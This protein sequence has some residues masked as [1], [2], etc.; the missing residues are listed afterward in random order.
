MANIVIVSSHCYLLCE[1]INHISIDVCGEDDLFER[2]DRPIEF[3]KNAN[4]SSRRKNSKKPKRLSKKEKE[5]KELEERTYYQITVNFVAVNRNVQGRMGNEDQ[6]T[7]QVIVHGRD[8]AMKLYKDMVDQIRNQ[9][10]DQLFL[11]DL[12]TRLLEGD[13]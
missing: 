13:K 6:R 10:P 2:N 9:I 8:E 7:V 11:N 4:R 12:V 3:A 1:A 5:Q